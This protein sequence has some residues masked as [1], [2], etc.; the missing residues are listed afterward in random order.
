MG[1]WRHSFPNKNH[2]FWTNENSPFVHN[3]ATCHSDFRAK[4]GKVQDAGVSFLGGSSVDGPEEPDVFVSNGHCCPARCVQWMSNNLRDCGPGAGSGAV[5]SN[6]FG[7]SS[8]RMAPGF[9]SRIRINSVFWSQLAQGF[10]GSLC[11]VQWVER[12]DP[13]CVLCCQLCQ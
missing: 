13:G 2:K 8:S 1:G 3:H 12:K 6:I 9:S 5:A 7:S 10:G 4:T 11:P